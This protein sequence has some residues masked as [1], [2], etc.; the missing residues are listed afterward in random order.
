MSRAY[1]I[2]LLIGAILVSVGPFALVAC[3][4]HSPDSLVNASEDSYAVWIALLK[5]FAGDVI[6]VGSDDA[7]AYFR[8]GRFLGHY[9]KVPACAVRLPESFTVGHGKPYVVGL[10][11]EQGEIRGVSDCARNEGYAIGQV[12]RK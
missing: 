11:V 9:Y 12:D 6:Y 10:H 4:P 8:I 3:Y 1:R 7:H 2:A 5:G